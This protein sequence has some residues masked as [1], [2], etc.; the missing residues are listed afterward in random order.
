MKGAMIRQDE[1]EESRT[2]RIKSRGLPRRLGR[3]NPPKNYRPRT[4]L[5]APPVTAALLQAERVLRTAENLQVG[6]FV[7]LTYD[8]GRGRAYELFGGVVPDGTARL[9][10]ALRK[11]RKGMTKAEVD[12]LAALRTYVAEGRVGG[13][14]IEVKPGGADDAVVIIP[15]RHVT[16][17]AVRVG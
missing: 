4:D 17:L 3:Y 11:I 15:L 5:S 6:D 2:L 9:N 13:R 8:D 12:E 7:R 10:W 14:E 1:R 16:G